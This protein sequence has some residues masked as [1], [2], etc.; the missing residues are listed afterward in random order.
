MNADE[1]GYAGQSNPVEG[2]PLKATLWLV[3]SITDTVAEL[4]SQFYYYSMWANLLASIYYQYYVLLYRVQVIANFLCVIARKV[5]R[6]FWVI[7][8]IFKTRAALSDIKKRRAA[9]RFI[10]YNKARTASILKER[11]LYPSCEFIHKEIFNIH[12]V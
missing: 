8:V 2:F 4:G 1:A 6:D 11:P 12:N 7:F 5:Q 10:S 3:F 9:D